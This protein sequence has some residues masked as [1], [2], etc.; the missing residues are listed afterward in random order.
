MSG[1]PYA[2]GDLFAVPLEGGKFALGVLAR[3]SGRGDALGY[4]FGPARGD[5]PEPTDVAVTPDEAIWVA[6][7]GDLGLIRREWP[8]LGPLPGWR[9]QEWPMPAFG[10]DELLTKRYLRVEYPDDEPDA[11]PCEVEIDEE[12]FRQL[13]EDGLAG[14]EFVRIRLN[15]LLEN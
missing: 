6:R 12:E 2:P 5:L 3:A 9:P 11:V 7:F 8:V 14:A 10:R 4:F 15:R 1:L 13:P